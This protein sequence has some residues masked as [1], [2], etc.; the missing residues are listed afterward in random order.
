MIVV[1]GWP[2]TGTSLLMQMLVAGGLEGLASDWTKTPKPHNPG[3]TW[4]LHTLAGSALRVLKPI[5]GD[6]DVCVKVFWAPLAAV[7]RRGLRPAGVVFTDRQAEAAARSRMAMSEGRIQP[8]PAMLRRTRSAALRELRLAH[9]PALE[10]NLRHLVDAPL[11]ASREL[12]AFL[13]PLVA[14]DLDPAAMA[15]VPSPELLHH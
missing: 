7:L 2:R 9:V 5:E 14:V 1:S 3:G 10:L 12:A 6:R 15:R 4:E 8:N 13:D 11:D